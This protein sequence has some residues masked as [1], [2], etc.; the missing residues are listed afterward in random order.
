MDK[1]QQLSDWQDKELTPEQIQYSAIDS[2]VAASIVDV[3]YKKYKNQVGQVCIINYDG[4][5]R[6]EKVVSP[7]VFII[8]IYLSGQGCDGILPE[9]VAQNSEKVQE[10]KG[11]GPKDKQ[12]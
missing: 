2:W 3:L 9:V 11:K 7:S 8:S 12:Q 5:E 4:R 10:N 6:C 1:E